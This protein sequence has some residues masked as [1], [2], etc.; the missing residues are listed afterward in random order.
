MGVEMTERQVGEFL[1][2]LRKVLLGRRG[3]LRIETG[4]AWT[5]NKDTGCREGKPNGT[6][7]Y[8]ILV[9]G[10]ARDTG[11]IPGDRA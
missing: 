6:W 2:H 3:S 11:D 1:E 4:I 7:T 9:N 10:G 5:T 8:T